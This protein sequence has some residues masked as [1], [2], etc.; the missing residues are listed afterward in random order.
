MYTEPK[1]TFK[2]CEE[3]NFIIKISGVY[4]CA[5]YLTKKRPP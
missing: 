4:A 3:Y 2:I 1:A 5:V